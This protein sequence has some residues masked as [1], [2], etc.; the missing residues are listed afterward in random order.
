MDIKQQEEWLEA[1]EP[2]ATEVIYLRQDLKSEISE[3]RECLHQQSHLQDSLQKEL[4]NFINVIENYSPIQG[5]KS[6]REMKNIVEQINL[7]T[8]QI[9]TAIPEEKLSVMNSKLEKL[10]N[11]ISQLRKEV[12]KQSEQLA[13]FPSWKLVVQIS[14]VFAFLVVCAMFSSYYIIIPSNSSLEKKID[15]VN[16]RNEQIWKKVK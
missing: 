14:F 8:K 9:Q 13:D 6:V 15:Q 7:K 3:I 16:N 4:N 1:L 10:D 11:T 5:Q 12:H 2:I